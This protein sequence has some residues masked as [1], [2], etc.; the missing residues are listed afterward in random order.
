MSGDQLFQE[1]LR[2][3]P[4]RPGCYMFRGQD[5]EVLYVGKALDLRKRVQVYR[6]EGADGRA[7]FAS[8]LEKAH[9]AEFFVTDNEREAILLEDGL[10]K[11]HQPPMNILLKDDK[12]FLLLNIDTTHQWPRLSLSRRQRQNSGKFFGPYPSATAARRTKRLLMQAFG[13]RDC[14]DHTI[15]NRTRACLKYSIGMCSGPCVGA[16]DAGEYASAV[17]AAEA[18]LNGDV[19]G[20]IEMERKRMATAS[21]KLEYEIAM[22][23]RDRALALE[24]LSAPQ[25]VRLAEA[26]D[27]DVIGIDVRGYF[28]ILN[29]REGD[30]VHTIRGHQPLVEEHAEAVAALISAAYRSTTAEIPPRILVPALPE[31][32]GSLADWLSELAG[33]KVSIVAP[34]RGEKRALVRMAESN[35]RSQRGETGSAS[36]PVVAQRLADMTLLPPPAVVDCIDVSHLQ[37]EHRV[38]SKVRFIEGRAERSQYRRYLVG[39]GTGNDDYAAM[40]E[41]VGRVLA[42]AKEDGLADLIVLDGGRLQLDAGLTSC[43]AHGLDAPLVALA[44]ARKGRGPVAAEERLFIPSKPT[45]LVLDRGTPERLFLERIRDEAHRFALAYHRSRRENLRLVL[46]DVPG[47]GP[48]KR[49]ILLTW[50]KGNLDQL[51]DCCASEIAELAGIDLPLAERLQAHLRQVM[52]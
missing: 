19:A 4:A 10:V 52:P 49:K 11:Q 33:H 41:V 42:R 1:Q 45:P 26:L 35:A 2:T 47:V 32:A 46:E 8:L 40:Q 24:A 30:W 12:S 28:A 13:I 50:C 5:D 14:S 44:K 7:R 34:S 9:C 31:A 37:G 51:R 16:V 21:A 15:N 38:A 36:W 29:Y 22:R 27:F 6:R 17:A 43:T 39:G 3:A 25:K 23:C 48:A 18:V 20:R